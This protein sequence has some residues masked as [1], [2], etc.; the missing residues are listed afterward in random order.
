MEIIKIW[1]SKSNRTITED[2]QKVLEQMFD[3]A[4]LYPLYL[5]LIFDIV[6]TWRS[7]DK[8]NY[9]E[10]DENQT[11]D[12][13]MEDNDFE[14]CTNID[15]C[16]QYLFK[17]MAKFHGQLL[18][19]HAIIYMTSF[20]GGIQ[21][22]EIKDILTLDDPVLEKVFSHHVPPDRKFPLALWTRIKY[23]LRD[24][25]V[26]RES[27]GKIV[28]YWYHRR[29]IEVANSY[30]I[31]RKGPKEREEIFQNVISLFNEYY[32]TN[33]KKVQ[34]SK[35]FEGSSLTEIERDTAD[36]KTIIYN[37]DGTVIT[38]KRKI[39]KLPEF[40]ARLS[41]NL[42]KPLACKY[43]FFDYD[44]LC[45]MLEVTPLENILNN[46]IAVKQSSS[47]S[48][49]K[50]KEEEETT[51][52]LNLMHLILLECGNRIK[53]YSKS[54]IFIILAKCL[55]FYKVG[56]YFK[57][58]IREFI[59]KNNSS[60][61]LMNQCLQLPGNDLAF[62]FEKHSTPI[63]HTIIGNYNSL[64]IFS[65]SWDSLKVFNMATVPSIFD[66]KIKRNSTGFDGL[67]IYLEKTPSFK[68]NDEIDKDILMFLKNSS[69]GFVV[70]TK[71][72]LISMSFEPRVHFS[73]QFDECNVAGVI[74]VSSKHILVYFEDKNYLIIYDIHKGLEKYKKT[75]E[76]NKIIKKVFSN[77]HLS[78]LNVLEQFTAPIYLFIDFKNSQQIGIFKVIKTEEENEEISIINCYNLSK[79]DFDLLSG[80]IFR[81]NQNSLI[82]DFFGMTFNNSTIAILPL[83][84]FFNE[85]LN[86]DYFDPNIQLIQLMG[87]R[88]RNIDDF[89]LTLIDTFGTNIL[90]IGSNEW[91]YFI[92]N[93]RNLSI[94][95][96][97]GPFDSA[98]FLTNRK[99]AAL[100]GG[101]I[102]IY[103]VF[104]SSSLKYYKII[105]LAQINAH[106]DRITCCRSLEFESLFLTSSL[107]STLRIFRHSRLDISKR[108]QLKFDKTKTEI[109][110]TIQIDN[111]HLVTYCSSK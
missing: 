87:K 68:Q 104:I 81:L 88:E 40:I 3:K 48:V 32:K 16:I 59:Q 105:K 60:L 36:Q 35:K 62:S 92:E 15:K 33:K 30:Y 98:S 84:D 107:D 61:A 6:I 73:H 78:Y 66:V 45:G 91:L 38:N 80:H 47:Y 71:S 58:L 101:L 95:R 14:M 83:Y 34:H 43:V 24:Y 26:E 13:D 50:S 53:D 103:K 4:T 100:R 51:K 18:F 65:L 77:S 27:G 90:M 22:D 39:E 109:I 54:G 9:N 89:K 111:L 10:E 74:L 55:Q 46:L 93:I 11:D 75:F 63:T 17:K 5:K 41:S 57:I 2:Q 79:G 29:F 106:A 94:G 70:Y 28:T 31:D 97:P 56:N 85:N 102:K 67:V 8:P 76:N 108:N 96:L 23:D 82:P 19:S 52:E 86:P 37:P 99:I 20:K 64:I 21:E 42:A 49:Q 12:D 110:K 1:L 7:F 72:E 69:G 44:F 25:I